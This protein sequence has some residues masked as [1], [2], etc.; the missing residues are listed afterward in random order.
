MTGG[1]AT[2]V[3]VTENNGTYTFTMPSYPVTV[4][5]IFVKKTHAVTI[6]IQGDDDC[7]KVTIDKTSLG[8]S[9]RRSYCNRNKR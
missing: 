1:E 9:W 3:D 8:R 6:K 2:T 5:A 7:G 4:S